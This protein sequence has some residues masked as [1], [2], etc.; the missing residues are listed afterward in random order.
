MKPSVVH[1]KVLEDDFKG[2]DPSAA[3]TD[4]RVQVDCMGQAFIRSYAVLTRTT[5][6]TDSVVAYYGVPTPV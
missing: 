5:N 6:V 2:A 4:F 1:V 3:I